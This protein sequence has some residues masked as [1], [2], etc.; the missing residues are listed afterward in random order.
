MT[1]CLMQLYNL[2][3]ESYVQDINNTLERV[4][5]I[6]YIKLQRMDANPHVLL[7]GPITKI[8]RMSPGNKKGIVVYLLDLETST[9]SLDSLV[10]ILEL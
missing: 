6:D 7:S 8:S 10:L 9:D 2:A 1:V 5:L 3:I 4:C